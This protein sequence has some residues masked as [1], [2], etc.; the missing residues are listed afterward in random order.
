MEARN[1]ADY[2]VREDWTLKEASAALEKAKE[3]V[4]TVE[5]FLK[6]VKK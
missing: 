1:N 2:N 6:L 3:F 4:E 5:K